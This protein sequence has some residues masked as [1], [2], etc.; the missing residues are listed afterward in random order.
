MFSIQNY[1][2]NQKRLEL[3]ESVGIGSKVQIVDNEDSSGKIGEITSDI[4]DGNYGVKFEDGSISQVPKES[5]IPLEESDL[6]AGDM[7]NEAWYD[8]NN[9]TKPKESIKENEELE[10]EVI[11]EE[12]EEIET[13]ELP[14]KSPNYDDLDEEEVKDERTEKILSALDRIENIIKKRP[15]LADEFAPKAEKL[16][17]LL[18]KENSQINLT[19][20]DKEVEKSLNESKDETVE[21]LKYKINRLEKIS[22]LNPKDKEFYSKK[23]NSLKK[24]LSEKEGSLNENPNK[25]DTE[26][27]KNTQPNS[28]IT[29]DSILESKIDKSLKLERIKQ[30]VIKEEKLKLLVS[31][32]IKEVREESKGDYKK[33]YV[34]EK[35]FLR[36]FNYQPF[37][38]WYKTYNEYIENGEELTGEEEFFEDTTYIID[39]LRRIIS[40]LKINEASYPGRASN[41]KLEN[42]DKALQQ[43]YPYMSKGDQKLKD[44]VFFG[45]YR[46]YNDGDFRSIN[47]PF[48]KKLGFSEDKIR[49]M[50][51]IKQD[52]NWDRSNTFD[53]P[54]ADRG[55]RDH[56]QK[57]FYIKDRQRGERYKGPLE[58]A[59]ELTMKYFISKY[60]DKYRE[61]KSQGKL[62]KIDENNDFKSELKNEFEGFKYV[63]VSQGGSIGNNSNYIP[64]FNGSVYKVFEDENEAKETAKRL[65]SRLTPGEKSYYKMSYKVFKIKTTDLDKLNIK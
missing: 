34:V 60:K 17:A 30:S 38:D 7:V 35:Q 18:E 29:D 44:D 23:L 42:I 39:F 22:K 13:T 45:Y 54:K 64:K 61:L 57:M 65:R 1:R 58:E 31:K 28:Q 25:S 5:I 9:K 40:K 62:S 11:T 51:S 49:I 26:S 19:I 53:R 55:R 8:K 37:D 50:K 33:S 15:E 52:H 14:E 36:S 24:E 21:S 20:K 10:E 3:L 32:L 59:L 48:L 47:F 56:E 2:N 41:G 63:V 12:A 6:A 16:K 4:N 46:F 43:I 27:I